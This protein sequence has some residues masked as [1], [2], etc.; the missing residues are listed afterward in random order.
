MLSLSFS[1]RY[2]ALRQV[3]AKGNFREWWS[4]FGIYPDSL[5]T[6]ARV[7]NTILVLGPGSGMNSTRHNLFSKQY[8][9]HMF[10][11][12]EY[13]EGHRDDEGQP[14]R[15]GLAF[16]IAAQM[17]AALARAGAHSQEEFLRMR[18]TGQYWFPVLPGPVPNLDLSGTVVEPEDASLL[19]SPL[20]MGENHEIVVSALAGKVGYLIWSA[21]GDDFHTKLIDADPVRN[22]LHNRSFSATLLGAAKAV[23]ADAGRVTFSTQNAGK[24]QINVR[25]SSMRNITDSFDRCLLDE[26]GLIEFW[27]PLNIWYRQVMKSTGDNLGSTY[28]SKEE[29]GRLGLTW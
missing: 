21:T 12:L 15:A 16:P 11:A 14:I 29:R 1:G 26:L 2:G 28:L 20:T 7:R 6:G 23:I 22:Y 5:F 13:E 17:I 4:S 9:P 10:S 27:R 18:P 8:R 19:K 3:F 24:R 25:W